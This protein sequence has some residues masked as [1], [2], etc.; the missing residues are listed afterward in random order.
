MNTVA[1]THW[2]TFSLTTITKLQDSK[3]PSGVPF[4]GSHLSFISREDKRLDST[5]SWHP[6]LILVGWVHLNS[7]LRHESWY[8]LQ[9]L[10]KGKLGWI[11]TVTFHITLQERLCTFDICNASDKADRSLCEK[12]YKTDVTCTLLYSGNIRKCSNCFRVARFTR[13][14]IHQRKHTEQASGFKFIHSRPP[15]GKNIVKGRPATIGNPLHCKHS[16]KMHS[17]AL[18]HNKLQSPIKG[19]LNFKLCLWMIALASL[20][21]TS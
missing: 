16:G 21:S 18:L 4:P 9:N 19:A 5:T 11:G 15:S 10:K 13:S 3:P 2:S 12:V 17:E 1:L 14:K 8:L 20:S 6:S 7:N